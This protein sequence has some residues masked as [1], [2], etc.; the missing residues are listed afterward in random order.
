[1]FSLKFKFFIMETQLALSREKQVVEVL[2]QIDLDPEMRE[3]L[4]GFLMK[5]VDGYDDQT[6]DPFGVGIN[7]L[8]IQNVSYPVPKSSA[9][10][11][12]AACLL[13]KKTVLT[14]GTLMGDKVRILLDE[15]ADRSLRK[16]NVLPDGSNARETMYELVDFLNEHFVYFNEQNGGFKSPRKYSGC[17]LRLALSE[18]MV[19]DVLQRCMAAVQISFDR[20]N[21][22]DYFQVAQTCHSIHEF[23]GRQDLSPENSSANTA[24]VQEMRKN[25]QTITRERIDRDISADQSRIAELKRL[26]DLRIEELIEEQRQSL[27]ARVEEVLST[28]MGIKRGEKFYG[29]APDVDLDGIFTDF[30]KI[31]GSKRSDRDIG[32]GVR[33]K[34]R[35]P[36]YVLSRYTELYGREVIMKI[37]KG[38]VGICNPLEVYVFG[39]VAKGTFDENSDVDLFVV[40][41]DEADVDGLHDALGQAGLTVGNDIVIRRSSQFV[42]NAEKIEM[43][44]SVISSQGKTVYKIGDRLR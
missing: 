22:I 28:R 9:Q 23:L 33:A 15:V 5:M 43:I 21:I 44:D 35:D 39:S 14:D 11:L 16:I 7:H 36:N 37:V 6:S 10:L 19:A 24:L 38:I 34:H 40:V 32:A 27:C 17:G 2:D 26:E 12:Q 1:M 31:S 8:G 13:E 3:C 4:L 42:E 20:G 41:D 29:L 30:S 25:H 18:Q